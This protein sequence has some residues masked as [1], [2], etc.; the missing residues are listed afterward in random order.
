[1]SVLRGYTCVEVREEL[2]RSDSFLLICESSALTQAQSSQQA[3]CILPIEPPPQ[4]NLINLVLLTLWLKI[5]DELIIITWP[6][7][8][9]WFLPVVVKKKK[10]RKKNYQSANILSRLSK[11]FIYFICVSVLPACISVHCVCARVQVLIG[12]ASQDWTNTSLSYCIVIFKTDLD[13]ENEFQHTAFYKW[14]V[15]I[16]KMTS[17]HKTSY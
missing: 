13:L 3:F 4:P 10:N 12:F 11:F 14:K 17:D 8:S 9:I 2:I 16:G 6:I 7:Y 5:N 1:M 15:Q